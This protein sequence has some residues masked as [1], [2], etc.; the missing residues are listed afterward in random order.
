MKKFFLPAICVATLMAQALTSCSSD[1]EPV[2]DE[3]LIPAVTSGAFLL[4]QG[5]YS[6]KI[7][8]SLNLL[9]FTTSTMTQNVF[10]T[11]NG[12]SLG[13]T[14]QCGVIYGSKMYIGM[15]ESNTIEIL[16]L[17]TCESLKQIRLENSTNGQQPRSM[18]TDGG[19]VYI[20]MYDG[21]VARL[22]TASMEIDASVK[23]GPN[24]EIITI[25]SGRIY[26]PNSDGMN[27]QNGYGTTASIVT[28]NPFKVESTFEVSLN[29]YKFFVR[30]SNLYL[31]S[32]GNYGDQQAAVYRIDGEESIHIA[33]ATMAVPY[34]NDIYL[35]N[36]PWGASVSYSRYNASTEQITPMSISNIDAPASIGI[37]P[38]S[39]TMLIS[40][41][42]L[43]NGKASY[44]LPGYVCRY[45]LSGNY[46][47]RFDMGV[48]EAVFMFIP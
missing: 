16:D 47:D 7:E 19:K 46:I 27:W 2:V 39:G 14:P 11:V 37:D 38:K 31:L 13:S 24:P 40:S 10:T 26:V 45:D 1:D 5:N 22:D 30:G 44:S 8:G 4:N 17:R 42:T 21:Y 33:D 32:R 36:A 43:E 12:R 20:S 41:Y 28:L 9:D 18:A 29:P 15:Y 48:G 25:Y 35:V 23:V 3:P 34:G 6:N